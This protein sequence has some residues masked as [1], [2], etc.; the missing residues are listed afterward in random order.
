MIANEIY[1]DLLAAVSNVGADLTGDCEQ[2]L[3][4]LRTSF[5]GTDEEFV[6]HV[7][8]NVD[9]WFR[10]VNSFPEWI[11]NADWQFHR[12]KPMVFVGATPI[13]KAAGLFHDEACV[14]V[15][16]S[17]DGVTKCVIQVS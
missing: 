7:Q 1:S 4:D 13:P 10:V 15:F 9:R 6:Q 5:Q 11:Q 12:G 2:F 3:S 8:A 14:F 17:D 16:L